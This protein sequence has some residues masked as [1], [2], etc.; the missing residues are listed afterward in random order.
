MSFLRGYILRVAGNADWS[1]ESKLWEY[2]DHVAIMHTGSPGFKHGQHRPELRVEYEHTALLLG[3]LEDMIVD[4]V[5]GMAEVEFETRVAVFRAWN[6]VLWVQN[7]LFA[8]HYVKGVE[9]VREGK[10]KV[11]AAGV[12]DGMVRDVVIGTL[13]GVLM[14]GLFTLLR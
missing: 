6:K 13:G 1:P 14:V 9:E 2:M 3:Y 7:D 11:G 12:W 8:R 10:E 4:A 5:M